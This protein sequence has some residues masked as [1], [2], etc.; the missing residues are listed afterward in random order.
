MHRA[1]RIAGTRPH[2]LLDFGRIIAL[3]AKGGKRRSCSGTGRL[4]AF[5]TVSLSLAL[6]DVSMAVPASSE[7][8]C[9]AWQSPSVSIA[10]ATYTTECRKVTLGHSIVWHF[11]N[12]AYK[13]CV[14]EAS[15]L[16]SD[17]PH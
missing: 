17:K 11:S 8:P 4:S 16:Q 13:V 15:A 1:L 5:R 12:C 14:G 2:G 7:S 3:Q 6:T 10:P 9:A